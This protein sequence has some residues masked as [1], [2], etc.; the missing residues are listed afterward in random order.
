MEGL[1]LTADDREVR[2]P[3]VRRPAQGDR[4]GAPHRSPAGGRLPA[5]VFDGGPARPQGHRVTGAAAVAGKT[6]GRFPAAGGEPAVRGISPA[7]GLHAEICTGQ[8]M[9]YARTRTTKNGHGRQQMRRLG[10]LFCVAIPVGL[11][12]AASPLAAVEIAPLP[13]RAIDRI[14]EGVPAESPYGW[15]GRGSPPRRWTASEPRPAPK[16][17]PPSQGGSPATVSTPLPP[18]APAAGGEET[19]VPPPPVP[20]VTAAPPSPP[21][22]RTR[23]PPH[24]L[25]SA[26][27]PRQPAAAVGSPAR[28]PSPRRRGRSR[29]SSSSSTTRTS[30]R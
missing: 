15:N 27:G 25:P 10:R 13:H 26:A 17:A 29:V 23:R 3:P 22:S 19:V 30:T 4:R 18:P 20:P 9:T 14:E 5:V 16:G 7:A 6:C 8:A 28:L 1:R 11:L 12:L 21:D 2:A 24:R